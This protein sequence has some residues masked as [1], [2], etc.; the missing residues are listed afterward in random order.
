M[1]GPNESEGIRFAARVASDPS[2]V[3]LLWKSL[4]GGKAVGCLRCGWVPEI[5]DAAGLLPILLDSEEAGAEFS[6]WI[7]AFLT[8]TAACAVPPGRNPSREVEALDRLEAIADWARSVS[9]S[10]VAEG[11]LWKSLRSY[12]AL[13]GHL[14]ALEER[15]LQDPGFLAP[16]E[17]RDIARAG[18]FLP[19]AAY[20]RLLC[21]IMGIDRESSATPDEGEG[22]DPWIFL[23]RRIA[24]EG[25]SP[26]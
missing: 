23:A 26:R 18:I 15:C 5:L 22:G 24:A 4:T 3:I 7:D 14:S 6:G 12:Q 16:H 20:S 19:A 11:L 10:P 9:G 8:D 2:G 1:R 17:R 13:R 21:S 25:T